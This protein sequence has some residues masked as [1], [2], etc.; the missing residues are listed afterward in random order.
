VR[1]GASGDGSDWDAVLADLP[2]ELQRGHTYYV[3]AGTY[4]AYTFDDAA[5]ADSVVTV[6]RATAARHGT[7]VGWQASYGQAG[8]EFGP[9]T[10]SSPYVMFDGQTPAGFEVIAEFQ[11]DAVVV[12]GDHVTIRYT[13]VNGNFGTDPGGIHNRGACTG[14][15]ISSDYVTVSGS[16]IHDA[17][18]DGV[19]VAGASYLDFSGNVVHALHACGTDG[20]CGPCYN[21][22]SDG[23]ETYN[24]KHS[25]FTGNFI[26]DVRSTA[27]F[28]FGNWADTLGGGPSEYCEDMLIENNVFYAPE[29]GLVAYIQDVA[30]AYVYNNVF[31][32]ARQGGYGGLSVGLNVTDLQLYN[33]VI[34]S[35]NMAHVGATFDPAEHHGDHNLFGVSLGQWTDGPNDRVAA[36]PGFMAIPDMNGTPVTNPVAAD[37]ALQVGSPCIDGGYAG[38]ATIQIPTADFTGVARDATPDIGAFER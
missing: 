28:F 15:S 22:H 16:T 19:S 3:A 33:N 12:T 34:L 20:G 18:D 6:R 36:D 11:G 38:D 4:A 5:S 23:L 26:Y 8:A 2:A 31:W 17:A 32:G 30:G 24:V 29:V 37:F 9:L 14:M 27:T 25:R 35:I 21:G 13:D 10:F 1:A 7:D